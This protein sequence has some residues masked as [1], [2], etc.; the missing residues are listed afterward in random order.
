MIAENQPKDK[1]LS[2]RWLRNYSLIVIGSFILA[3]AYVYFITPYRIVPGG[4]YGISIVIHYLTP[5]VFAFAP[6]GFPIGLMGLLLNIPLTILGV[7]IL[8]PLFGV[9]TVV[10]FVL[11]SFFIDGLTAIWGYQPLVPNDALLSSIFGGVLSGFALGLIFKAKAT[12]GGSDIV[13][14]IFA[15]YT[16]LPLGQL[17]IYVD[18]TIVLV[19]LIAFGDWR[20]PLY[21]WIVIYVTGKVIDAVMQG[22]GYDKSLLIISDHYEEIRHKILF[23]L[24]RGATALKAEGMY[25][26]KEKKVI[27][28]NVSRRELAILQEYI[29]GIDADAFLTVFDA[30]EIIG[31]GFKTFSDL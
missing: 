20:I 13:A 18:S 26:G 10:G 15:K 14:M 2:K 31:N 29:K 7:R 21:S 17:M 8:G 27:F 6:E 12:S 22:I 16:R 9:K 11:S 24:S 28:T 3:V 30:N 25:E 23:D 4:V 5:H 19:G 1:F